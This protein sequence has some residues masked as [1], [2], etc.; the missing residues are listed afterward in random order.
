MAKFLRRYWKTLSFFGIT[1]LIGG[2]FVGIYVLDSYPPDIQQQLYAQLAAESLAQ[3]PVDVFLG[4]VSAIQSVGYGVILGAAGIWLAKQIG[5]WK[6]ETSIRPAPLTAAIAVGVAGGLVMI[7]ADML[8]FNNFSDVIKNSYATKPTIPY[9]LAMVTYGGVIEEVLLRLFLM[10]LIAWI[11]H[12]LL[13]KTECSPSSTIL[14]CANVISAI[15]FAAGHL[16][17]TLLMIG[18]APV[19]IFRCFLL[20]GGIGLLFGWLYRKFGLRYAMIAHGGCH[21][22]SKLIWILFI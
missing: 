19:I 13:G 16:P 3:V 14:I 21:I 15:L 7:L 22:I 11:L 2:Y 5:L 1:G 18:D 20:N 8:Y 10:S 4:I 12:K 9:L 6:D 17:T